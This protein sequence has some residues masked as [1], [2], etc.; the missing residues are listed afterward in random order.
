MLLWAMVTSRGIASYLPGAD[1]GL[2][3]ETLGIEQHGGAAAHQTTL[4]LAAAPPAGDM[5]VRDG[6]HSHVQLLFLEMVY[7]HGEQHVT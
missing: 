7:A 5:Q 3:G 4:E 6:S 2:V 1:G